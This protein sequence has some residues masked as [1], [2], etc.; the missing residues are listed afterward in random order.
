MFLLRK[1]FY[2][3]AGECFRFGWLIKTAYSFA[4]SGDYGKVLDKPNEQYTDFF[5]NYLKGEFQWGPDQTTAILSPIW[6]DIAGREW[7]QLFES[8][9]SGKGLGEIYNNFLNSNLVAGIED[10]ISTDGRTTIKDLYY[11]YR[12]SRQIL[13]YGEEIG[14]VTPNFFHQPSTHLM[15][16][17]LN[18][19]LGNF[20][21]KFELDKFNCFRAFVGDNTR[22]PTDLPDVA[23]FNDFIESVLGIQ[24]S[25]I[26]LLRFCELGGGGALFATEFLRRH[27][28]NNYIFADLVPFLAWQ[29]ALLGDRCKFLP[30]ECYDLWNLEVDVL[31]NQDSFPEMPGDILFEYIVK[32]KSLG[33]SHIFSYNQHSRLREQSDYCSILQSLNFEL[34]QSLSSSVRK[35]YRLEYFRLKQSLTSEV[36]D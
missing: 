5:E 33:C 28:T 13:S 25:E 34:V 8:F 32:L 2:Y 6:K 18:G 4:G 27:R 22:Y 36:R 35:G 26:D 24:E 1:F 3:F 29:F 11:A 23:Y 14:L 31:I 15:K 16:K 9:Q 19:L 30:A 12:F 7:I 17:E 21:K 10:D 20:S